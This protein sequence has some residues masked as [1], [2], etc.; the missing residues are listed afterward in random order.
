M[1]IKKYMLFAF[2]ALL[3]V[4][5]HDDGNWG[6]K[7]WQQEDPTYGIES[8]GNQ[9]LKA[10]NLRSISQVKAMFSSEISSGSLKQVTESMQIQ[11]VVV[12][13]DEGGNIYQ[14]LYIQDL[15]GAISISISQAG[16]YGAFSIG[17]AV[18]IELNGLY[19]GG[20]GEQPQIGTTYTNP[21]NGN[22]QTGRMSRYE[23]QKHYKLLEG[24]EGLSVAPIEVTSMNGLSLDDD[25][26]KLITL[27]NVELTAANGK[28]TYAPSDGSVTLTSNCAN[29]E[30]KDMKN[31][32]LRT[33]TYA[34]FANAVMPT[35]KV[36]ITG[37]ASRFGT[38][39]QILMRTEKDIQAAQ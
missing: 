16:L 27:K 29:R 9:K 39:W 19:I 20:Y 26:C 2:T 4:S 33:S 7:P 38:T 31:V 13:N 15:S 12:G 8:Y 11:G 3:S 35:G 37:I 25:C 14:S 23:W 34:D 24:I 28:A 10:T 6:K 18:L 1:K 22:V 17:Q 36:D 5:C 21:K 30:I 32:V